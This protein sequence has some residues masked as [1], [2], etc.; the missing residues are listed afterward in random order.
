MIPSKLD[1]KNRTARLDDQAAA[2]FK[3]KVGGRSLP[4]SGSDFVIL[5]L[6]S[7]IERQNQRG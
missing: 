4:L 5:E 2:A 3:S 6:C 7:N 1:H